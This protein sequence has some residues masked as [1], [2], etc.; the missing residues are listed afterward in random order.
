MRQAEFGIDLDDA[1]RLIDGADVFVV[2]F[3]VTDRRLLVDAR[4]SDDEGPM[5]RVV[6]RAGSVKE[7]FRS[8]KMM[9]PR[10]RVPERIHTFNWPRHAH[11]LA[12]AGLWEHME[13]RLVGL[14]GAEAERQ[15]AEAFAELVQDERDVELAAIRGGDTFHTKWSSDGHADE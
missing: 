6:P 8:L 3:V 4:T 13:R 9:R 10:F 14:G 12:E 2:R 11:A 15:C 5:I 1:R 7:R